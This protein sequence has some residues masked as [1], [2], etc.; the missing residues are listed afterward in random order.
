MVPL[1]APLAL[2]LLPLIG[3]SV[4]ASA[5]ALVSAPTTDPTIFNTTSSSAIAFDKTHN[6]TYLGVTVDGVEK[7]LGIPYGLPTNGTRRFANP[8]PV[9]VRAGGVV[10][11]TD[12]GHACPQPDVSAYS[13]GKNVS[14]GEDC[15]WLKVARPAGVKEGDRLPVMVYIYGGSLFSGNINDPTADPGGLIQQSVDNGLPVVYVAMNYR[16]NIFGFALSDALKEDNS[17]NVGMKDQR[18]ALEWVQENIGHF[19]GDP[20]RVTIFGQSSGGLSVGIQVLAYG[21]SRPA[22]FTGAIMESTA[23]EPTSS[24][25]LSSTAFASIAAALNCTTTSSNGTVSADSAATIACLRGVSWETLLA[26]AVAQAATSTGDG[27]IWLPTVDNDFLPAKQ[28][29]LVRRGA[30]AS[31]IRIMAGWTQDDATLFLPTT[32][33]STTQAVRD[34]LHSY[35]PGLTD[36]TVERLVEL[37]P[38]DEFSP[39]VTAGLPAD[40]YRAARVFRDILLVCPAL[41]LGEAA[42]DKHLLSTNST[43]SPPVYYYIQNQTLTEAWEASIGYPGRGVIHTSELPY[44]FANFTPFVAKS[45]ATIRPSSADYALLRQTSRSWSSFAWFGAPSVEGRD[46][47]PGWTGAYAEASGTHVYVIGGPAPGLSALEGEGA[48]D[49]V[50]DQRLGERCRFL[51]SE[52]VVEE[53]Q[54]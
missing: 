53:L 48:R 12:Y 4:S 47:L 40:F 50:G 43:S 37:Y 33:I 1:I 30:F 5:S 44:V 10:D 52:E 23:L 16:L 18:L 21:G 41:L 25:N 14:Q 49:V 38:A 35:W 32:N 51:N 29:E 11:A 39:N 9:P 24:S 36:A 27:D 8:E 3:V 26:A 34:F 13:F 46:T 31:N 28:S 54:Y 6:T 20:S 17:L 15:L 45:P 42:R 19:G 2:S 7:F 22:P